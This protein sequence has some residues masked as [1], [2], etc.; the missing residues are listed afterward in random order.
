MDTHRFAAEHPVGHDIRR[1]GDTLICTT[2]EVEAHCPPT[3][4]RT[5]TPM[6][7]SLSRFD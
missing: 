7:G 4:R 1:D 6:E 2:C 5:P 3:P